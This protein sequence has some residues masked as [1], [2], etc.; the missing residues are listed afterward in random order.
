MHDLHVPF[1]DRKAIKT[2]LDFTKDIKP[3]ILVCHEFID[4]Y[5]ISKFDRDPARLNDLQYDLDE[6][7]DIISQ[8]RKALP[9]TTIVMVSSNHDA[10]LEKYKRSV[11]AEL[12]SLR[13]LE[14]TNLLELPK[15]NIKYLDHY[16]FRG[17]LFKHGDIVRKDSGATAKAE[18]LREGVSGAS[19]HS[20]RLGKIYKTLRGGKYTWVEGGCLCLTTGVD[21]IH[22][23]ADWQQ[24]L[25]AFMFKDNSNH[26]QAFDIPIIDYEIVWGCK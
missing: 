12:H 17:V 7:K 2:A 5:S 19:G 3:I 21:Y 24:G 8:I 9:K 13:C 10:R 6:T 23:V 26:F 16:M 18:F 1:H 14:L 11:A 20:H 4:F 15:F 22:G 25:S